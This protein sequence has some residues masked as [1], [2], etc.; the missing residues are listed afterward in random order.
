MFRLGK[1][2]EIGIGQANR[3]DHG[4]VEFCDD[5]DDKPVDSSSFKI[6][7]PARARSGKVTL[8]ACNRKP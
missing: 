6:V 4:A 5:S 8:S 7:I 2:V 3:A 1:P